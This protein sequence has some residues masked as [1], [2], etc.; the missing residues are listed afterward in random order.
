MEGAP[1]VANQIDLFMHFLGAS[2]DGLVTRPVEMDKLSSSVSTL[3]I[4]MSVCCIM[5]YHDQ[6]RPTG[7]HSCW[8]LDMSVICYPPP[9][10][11]HTPISE[12]GIIMI[13]GN[14]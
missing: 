2:R 10:H 8:Y 9:P 12:G 5:E 6:T 4:Q 1:P 7:S 13:V 3:I 11:T 14:Y